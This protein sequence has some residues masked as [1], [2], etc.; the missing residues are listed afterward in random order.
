MKIAFKILFFSVI[1]LIASCKGTSVSNAISGYDKIIQNNSDFEVK[2]IRYT[3]HM[4]ASRYSI[5]TLIIGKNMSEIIGG[6]NS[7]GNIR[8]CRELRELRESEANFIPIY[9]ESSEKLIPDVNDRK[10]WKYKFIKDEKGEN[11]DG[12]CECRMILTNDILLNL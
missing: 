5:D 6:S 1:V 11:G 2:I 4:A 9:V 12:K 10:L 8:N 3:Y 7:I